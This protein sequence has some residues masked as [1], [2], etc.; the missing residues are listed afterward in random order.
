[1]KETAH[2]AL[3]RDSADTV[4][5]SSAY[6]APIQYYSKLI[7][8]KQVYIESACNY[9]K[10]TYRNR[11]NIAAANGELSLTIP[12]DKG[13]ELKC[14]TKDIRIANQTDWQ[15]QHWRSIESAYKTSPFFDYYQDDFRPFFEKEWKFLWDFNSQIQQLVLSLLELNISVNQTTTFNKHVQEHAVDARELIH[16]KKDALTTDTHFKS[17]AYYQVFAEKNG[18]IPNLSIIDLLFN[19]GNEARLVLKQSWI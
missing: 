11:C 2:T 16:P 4:Y 6:L 3:E 17:I 13:A 8:Y 15:R 1:M 19:M 9:M 12:V 18:F 10:Q 7:H 5:L 14:K